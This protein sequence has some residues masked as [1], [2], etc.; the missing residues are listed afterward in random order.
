V[1]VEITLTNLADDV[2]NFTY[3]CEVPISLC[4][5]TLPVPCMLADGKKGSVVQEGEMVRSGVKT[6]KVHDEP[7]STMLSLV[8]DSRFTLLKEDYTIDERTTVGDETIYLHT[9]F[10]PCWSLSLEGGE[11]KKI[12]LGLRVE[13]K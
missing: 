12:T 7:N 5:K 11:Q 2:A 3:G 6:I 9:L 13:R 8:C 4:A 10:M 1:F